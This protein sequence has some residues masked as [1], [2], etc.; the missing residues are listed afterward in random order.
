MKLVLLAKYVII[1]HN[2]E[3]SLQL[4]YRLVVSHGEGNVTKSTN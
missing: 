3:M 4:S 2:T 1:I